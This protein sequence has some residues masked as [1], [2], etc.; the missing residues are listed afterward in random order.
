MGLVSKTSLIDRAAFEYSWNA[1][2]GD[3]PHI[4]GK[5]DSGRVSRKEGYEVVDYINAFA[6]KHSLTQA[7]SGHKIEDLLHKCKEVMRK[8][9]TAWIEANWSK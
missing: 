2:T 1:V 7:G 9:V 4:T 5:P 8:D 3:N 6:K